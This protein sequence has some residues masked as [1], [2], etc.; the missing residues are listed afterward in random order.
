MIPA[1]DLQACAATPWQATPDMALRTAIWAGLLVV[2]GWAT[3]RG[4]FPGRR[5]FV[6][7][8]LAMAAWIGLSVMEHA[9]VDAVC[10]GTLGVL[11]WAAT[12]SQPALL[13]LFL[14]QYLNSETH[15]PSLRARLLMA[16]PIAA[17][18]IVAWTNGAHGL[19]YG[20]GTLLGPP[21][22][23][24]PRLFYDYGPFFYAAMALGYFW[25]TMAL[26]LTLRGWRGATPSQRGQWTAFLAMMAVPLAANVAY[27][28]FGVRLLGA[29]PT[30]TGFAFAVIGFAWMIARNRLFAVVPMARERLFAELPDPVFVLDLDR[31]VIDANRAA[32]RLVGAVARF[33]EPLAAWPRLGAALELHQ[34]AGADRAP[35]ELAEPHAIYEVQRRELGA[36]DRPIGAL[37]Q[38]HDITERERAH[39]QAMRTLA[40]RELELD[41][42]TALQVLL[43]EQAMHDPLTGLLNRRALQERYAQEVRLGRSRTLALVLLD[44]DHFKQ[45]NDT[46][47]HPVGDA[48]LRD[49]AAALRSGLRAGDALFRIG[50]E[51]FALLMAQASIATATQRVDDL[52]DL[53]A[54]WRLGGLEEAVTF[55]AGVAASQ[56]ARS[57]LES[58]LAAADRALYRA[59]QSGRDRIEV[60]MAED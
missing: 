42:A 9:A 38:L 4:A 21:I 41:H 8:V 45:I 20:P 26:V 7:M 6:G 25:L 16:A 39:T 28:G 32:Q 60:A 52:R 3:A 37:L 48:V 30:S 44:L 13:A 2:A 18:V 36:P 49:F 5:S 31:R 27:V 47:G 43:R 51:E 58:L 12:L 14:Y 35:L 29:D 34:A 24:L 59:K 33:G 57:S 54:R 46:H 1:L 17:L 40:A 22:A 19:F 50:G 15:A 53:L 55:S 56:P 23:G 10:K 11:S